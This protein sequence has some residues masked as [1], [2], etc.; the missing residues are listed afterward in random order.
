MKKKV[1]DILCVQ[2][3]NSC[4]GMCWACYMGV[5]EKFCLKRVLNNYKDKPYLILRELY[6]EIEVVK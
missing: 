2:L 5:K 3:N 6:K 1:I 4:D